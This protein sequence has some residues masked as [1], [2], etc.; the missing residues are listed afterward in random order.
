MNSITEHIG[1]DNNYLFGLAESR[2]GILTPLPNG[3][4][5]PRTRYYWTFAKS[6]AVITRKFNK[7]G[8]FVNKRIF[9]YHPHVSIF[10]KRVIHDFL[11]ISPFID[12]RSSAALLPEEVMHCIIE[13]NF[14]VEV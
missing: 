5:Y 2:D 10:T 3:G 14:H 9:E 6:K 1:K 7:I 13:D 4:C 11:Q 12:P 8:D